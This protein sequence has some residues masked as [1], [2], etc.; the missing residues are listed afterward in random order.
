ML[1]PASGT[2]S[3]VGVAPPLQGRGI[4]TALVTWASQILSQA[5]TRACHIGWTGSEAFYRRAGY[6]PCRRYAMFHSPASHEHSQP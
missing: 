6:Q 4:G 3:C 2:I 1:G 5:G